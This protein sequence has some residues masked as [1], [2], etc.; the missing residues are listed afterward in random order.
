MYISGRFKQTVYSF[1]VKEN[2]IKLFV[3]RKKLSVKKKIEG[4]FN[5]FKVFICN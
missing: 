4:T 1:C 3:G 5:C 2:D